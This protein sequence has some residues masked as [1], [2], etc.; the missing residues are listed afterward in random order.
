MSGNAEVV[1][2]RFRGAVE[3][4]DDL[5]RAVTL[6]RGARGGCSEY[7][8]GMLDRIIPGLSEA[9]MVQRNYAA[10]LWKETESARAQ[11]REAAEVAAALAAKD[12][13]KKEAGP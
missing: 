13:A 11:E 1:E 8:A 6:V 9:E 4:R 12:E 10:D 2:S 3:A 5:S 7:A